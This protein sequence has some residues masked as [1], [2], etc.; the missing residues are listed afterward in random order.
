MTLNTCSYAKINR[1]GAERRFAAQSARRGTPSRRPYRPS[2]PSLP[3]PLKWPGRGLTSEPGASFRAG[4]ARQA[5][6]FVVPLFP[7]PY[8]PAHPAHRQ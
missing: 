6:L 5:L 3:P 4:I 8:P 7:R 2:P 1:W